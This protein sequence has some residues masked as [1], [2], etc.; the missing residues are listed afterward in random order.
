MAV[1]W[2]GA[3]TGGG[4]RDGADATDSSGIVRPFP[5]L[6]PVGEAEVVG[7]DRVGATFTRG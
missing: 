3:S 4:C 7:L 1:V 6:D 5:V 2:W